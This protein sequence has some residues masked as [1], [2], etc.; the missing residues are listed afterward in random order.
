MKLQTAASTVVKGICFGPEKKRQLDDLMNSREAMTLTKY[1]LSKKFDITNV[2][3]NKASKIVP[4]SSPIAFNRIDIDNSTVNLSA[5][6]SIMQGQLINIKAT[7]HEI[8]GTKVVS[9]LSGENLTKQEAVLLDP[10]GCVKVVLWERFV[11]KITRG[12]TYLFKNLSLKKDH[13]N[14]EIYVNTTV[15][16]SEILEG[17]PFQLPLAVDSTAQLNVFSQTE[18]AAEIIGISSLISH[19]TCKACNRPLEEKGNVRKVC[20]V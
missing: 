5:I 12:K 10:F 7:V 16:G 3:I 19:Y 6:N 15:S 11:D 1:D 14:N 8:G 20:F 13:Y 9:R 2:V 4:C 18:V 17:S